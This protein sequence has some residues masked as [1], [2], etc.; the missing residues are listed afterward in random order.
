MIEGKRRQIDVYGIQILNLPAY[1]I[2]MI[3]IKCKS[4][5]KIRRNLRVCNKI[6]K[7]F[8]WKVVANSTSRHNNQ[9]KAL[10]VLLHKDTGFDINSM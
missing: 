5:T 6:L 9:A 10:Y 3:L 2:S 8:A 1:G 7:E 4:L